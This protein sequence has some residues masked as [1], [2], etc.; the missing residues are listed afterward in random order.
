MRAAGC[1][2]LIAGSLLLGACAQ[3]ALPEPAFNTPSALSYINA[4]GAKVEVRVP[5]QGF[6]TASMVIDSKTALN[7]AQVSDNVTRTAVNAGGVVGL[8]IASAI[9][10]RTGVGALERDARQSAENDARPMAALLAEQNLEAAFT[11]RYQHTS[12]A[13]GLPAAQGPVSALVL[14]EPRLVLSADRGS[15]VLVNRVQVQDIAGSVLYQRRIEV[16]GQPFRSCGAQCIDDGHLESAKVNAQLEVCIDEAMRVF[17][18]DLRAVDSQAEVE[19]TVR[20]VL[21][22]RRV[23]ERGRLLPSAGVYHRYR[24]LDGAI[25]SVPMPFENVAVQTVAP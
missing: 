12:Q 7:A 1:A 21:D 20:Y 19:Q 25:K 9:N 24:N 11:Q 18:Q 3:H 17:A 4:H 22:G 6:I 14:I 8:L 16:V 15:F 13:A 10:T 2:L 23:V 5:A